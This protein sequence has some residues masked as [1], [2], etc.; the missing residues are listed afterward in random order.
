MG[1]ISRLSSIAIVGAGTGGIGALRALLELP[2]DIRTGWKIDV[3]EQTASVGGIW[4]PQPNPPSPPELP[5]TP[6]YPALRTNTPHPTM[7]YPHFPF[8]PMT[9]LFPHHDALQ[10]YHDDYVEH[11]NMRPFIHFNTSVVNATYDQALHWDI[12]VQR[13]DG[14]TSH[15]HYDQL[16][17]ANG[18]NRYPYSP[19]WDGE[20]EWLRQGDGQRQ[21]LHSLWYREPEKYAGRFVIVVGDGA[22]G[23]DMAQ[24]TVPLAGKVYHSY[25]ND[26]IKPIKLPPVPGTIVKPRISHFTENAIVFIDNTTLETPLNTTILLATGYSLLVPWLTQL[27]VSPPDGVDDTTLNLTTNKRYIRPLYRHCLSLDPSIPPNALSFV[28]LPLWI[29]NAPSDYA[30]GQLV[31][32]TIADP[33]WL[34]SREEL[35]ADLEEQESG[36]QKQGIDPYRYGHAFTGEGASEAYMNGLIDLLRNKSSIPLPDFLADK[37][38]P[39]LE[40]WRRRNREQTWLTR[41]GWLR[42]EQLGIQDSFIKGAETEDD[43]VHVLERIAEWERKQEEEHGPIEVV[44]E[45]L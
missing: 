13:A 4:V 10:Q 23:R 26:T 12:T 42:A 36:L 7:T 34:P 40:P 21:I 5:T 6:L 15:G 27:T 45:P 11:F 30:Q 19:H 43:W 37:S 44:E 3:F 8:P 14:D 2:E 38:K 18:H 33:H 24:Q 39:Y 32:H 17:V 20:D 41:R 16:V 9:N 29:A 25:D 28:G 22:S 35:L 31:A 1:T